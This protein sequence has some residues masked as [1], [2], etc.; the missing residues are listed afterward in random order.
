MVV[1]GP[2][3]IGLV[4]LFRRP[5]QIWVQTRRTARAFFATTGEKGMPVPRPGQY[6]GGLLGSIEYSYWGD[7]VPPGEKRTSTHVPIAS[8]IAQTSA[9]LLFST[10]PELKTTLDGAAGRANQAWLDELIDDGF[11]TRLLEAAEMC[12]ALGG[13]Y[14][15][16]VWDTQRQR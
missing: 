7:P 1:S 3:E 6:R 16:I 12:S 10:P 15:R 5:P 8:D 14:L 9:S 4:L 2:T 11:H 13:V